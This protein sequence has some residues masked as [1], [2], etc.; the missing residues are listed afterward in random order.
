MGNETKATKRTPRTPGTVLVSV[1][2][3]AEL[4]GKAKAFAALGGTTLEVALVA[5]V[6]AAYGDVRIAGGMKP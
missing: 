4:H 5:A 2:M 3:P 1:E 6:R